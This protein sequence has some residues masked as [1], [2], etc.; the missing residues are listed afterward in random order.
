M[1]RRARQGAGRPA[2]TLHATHARRAP[3]ADPGWPPRR[4]G[5]SC[6]PTRAW[7]CSRPPRPTP[8]RG[9]VA[10][11]GTYCGKSTIYLAAA[12]RAGRPG[13][14]DRGPPPR[15]GGEPA[16]LGV[17]RHRAGRPGHRPAGHAAA[18]PG[19]AGRGRAGGA[20]DRDRRPVGRRWPRCGGRRW[21][22]CSSTAATPTPRPSP[23]TRAGRRGWRTAARWPSTTC[24]PTRPTAARRRTG[25]IQRAL[26]SGAFTQVRVAGSL[27]VLERTGEGIG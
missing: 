14:G 22:C 15:L 9:P 5:A 20:G 18:L 19:H 2:L 13:G 10:E 7:P 11:I 16:R 17:P 23:T 21:A 6:R 3:G 26:A 12:V 8:P 4:P 27:R 25:S 24:S 1:P